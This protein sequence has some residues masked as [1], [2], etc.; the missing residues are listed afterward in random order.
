MRTAVGALDPLPILVFVMVL[1]P[2]RAVHEK[3]HAALPQ[4][5]DSLTREIIVPDS[6]CAVSLIVRDQ[7]IFLQTISKLQPSSWV[8]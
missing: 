8:S 7:T 2:V 4:W 5:C 6:S 3:A 1:P